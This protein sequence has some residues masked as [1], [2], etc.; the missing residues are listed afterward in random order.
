[1]LRV[2]L[3]SLGFLLLSVV[4]V[5][6]H[7]YSD[8]HR[9]SERALVKSSAEWPT[10]KCQNGDPGTPYKNFTVGSTGKAAYSWT[11]QGDIPQIPTKNNGTVLQ[12]GKINPA[13]PA[14]RHKKRDYDLLG[15]ACTVWCNSGTNGPD[16]NDCN[17]LLTSDEM[18]GTFTIP[19][20]SYL[21]WTWLTCQVVQNNLVNPS[22]AIE[23]SYDINNWAGVVSNLAYNCQAAENAMGGSCHFADSTAISVIQVQLAPASS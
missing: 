11:C 6:A 17:Q 12:K 15:E 22:V 9:H 1:M 19:A 3:F 21:V 18:S 16:P 8:V 7:P 4:V 14:P 23:Y 13:P 20:G 2:S 5:H 10:Y